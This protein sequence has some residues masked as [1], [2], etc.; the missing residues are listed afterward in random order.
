[1]LQENQ[2]HPNTHIR[3]SDRDDYLLLQSDAYRNLL[4]S[5]TEAHTCEILF[6]NL[7]IGELYCLTTITPLIQDKVHDHIRRR[8]GFQGNMRDIIHYMVYLGNFR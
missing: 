5:E 1:M 7:S 2:I 4:E 6:D 3:W 8:R